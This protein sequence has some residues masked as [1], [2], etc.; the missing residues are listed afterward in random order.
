VQVDPALAAFCSSFQA[1]RVSIVQRCGG[2]AAEIAARFV[3]YDACLAFA[4]AVAA[5]RMVFN[6]DEAAACLAAMDAVACDTD[7]APR[8]C[9][10]ALR[11]TLAPGNTCNLAAVINGL[12]ECEVG[13]FCVPLLAGGG[14][15]GTCVAGA[16]LNQPCGGAQQP[17]LSGE[18]C[19]L[20]GTCTLKASSG[21]ECGI[22]TIPVCEQGLV[23]SDLFGGTCGP[24]KGAGATCS[25]QFTEC[26][27]PLQCDR[28]LALTGTCKM[29][30][31][32]GAACVIDD[33]E[34]G[35]GFSYCGAD[36]KCHA[37]AGIG[38]P[39]VNSDGEGTYCMFG[40]CD[41]A[42]A[43]PVCKPFATG[44]SCT[45]SADCAPGA[46]CQPN[47]NGYRVCTASCL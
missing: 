40:M 42:L 9:D 43:T 6:P 22:Q 13:T 25:G 39:C 3:A 21:S 10:R 35:I 46:L 5:G 16:G 38:D 1:V 18:T 41:T 29:P 20:A 34:C 36:S 23:C 28:G 17:C 47:Q 24:R 15:Q 30:P 4:P 7:T 8:E 32:P 26:E 19:T 44:A 12:S 45:A 14:C 33:F 2:I 11:G 27:F 37:L 31:A